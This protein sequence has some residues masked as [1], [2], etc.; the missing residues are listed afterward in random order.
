[1]EDEREQLQFL[2]QVLNSIKMAGLPYRK[3]ISREGAIVMLLKN[4][5]ETKG[6]LNG[7][8]L[9]VRKMFREHFRFGDYSW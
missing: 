3:L 1:M 8:R 4:L 5:N 6:L 9:I 7:T 2:A